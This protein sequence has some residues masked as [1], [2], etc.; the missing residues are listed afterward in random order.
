MTL[1]PGFVAVPLKDAVVVIA[2][3]MCVVV[4]TWAGVSTS[5]EEWGA[6]PLSSACG[7]VAMGRY[8]AD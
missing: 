6:T 2:E 7:W 4:F 5:H 1:P 8:P 3:R